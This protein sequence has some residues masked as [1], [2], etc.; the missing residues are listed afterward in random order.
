MRANA[1]IYSV[2]SL[3]MIELKTGS[4]NKKWINLLIIAAAVVVIAA[5][6]WAIYY[7]IVA[8]PRVGM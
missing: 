4:M 1:M 6:A 2:K 7:F 5:L 3:Q 8:D